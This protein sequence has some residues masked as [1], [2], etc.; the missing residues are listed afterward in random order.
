MPDKARGC[1]TVTCVMCSWVCGSWEGGRCSSSSPV[2]SAW[3]PQTSVLP[4]SSCLQLWTALSI[5]AHENMSSPQDPGG[6]SR[7]CI[8][9]PP[10]Y[11]VVLTASS[12]SRKKEKKKKKF[13]AL[14]WVLSHLFLPANTMGFSVLIPDLLGRGCLVIFHRREREWVWSLGNR[15]Q[16]WLC[17]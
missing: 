1:K 12:I 14:S 7:F 4:M 15:P 5:S 13:P 2:P 8:C 9:H 6:I 3:P 17:L 11:T 16:A 10:F